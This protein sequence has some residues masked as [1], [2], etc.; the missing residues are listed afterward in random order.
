MVFSSVLFVCYFLPTL[1]VLYFIVPRQFKNL[2]LLLVS[3]FFYSWGAPKFIFAILLTTSI[4]FMLVS[5]MD[6]QE[7]QKRRKILMILSVLLNVSLLF[8]FKYCDFFIANINSLLATADIKPMKLLEVVLP[9]GI[10]FYTFESL[11][12]VIDVYRK[13]HQPLNDFINYLLYII[14]FPKLI[15]G[16]IIR[17]HEIAQQITH[18]FETHTID[19]VLI[20]FRRFA[21]GLSKKVIIANSLAIVVA[22][23]F[24]AQAKDLTAY[25]AWVGMIG[26]TF[27]I[28]FDFSGYSDMAIGIGQMLGF[29]F[30]ENFNNPYTSTSISD[31]WRKWHI[32]LGTWMKNYLY[33]PLGGNQVDSKFRLFFNLW[34]V[35]L[36]SGFW[37][38]AKWTFIF[39]GVYHG[40]WLVLD[41]LGFE[42]ILKKLGRLG[43]VFITFLLTAFGWVWFNANTFPEGTL[44][45]RKLFVFRES[46]LEINITPVFWVALLFSALFSFWNLLPRFP[47]LQEKL[48]FSKLNISSTMSLSILSLFFI[49]I[50]TSFMLTSQFNPFIYFRF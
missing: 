47:Q 1:L 32:T 41:R 7:T 33:I 35:F 38:G 39:W 25:Y 29:T 16:P 4:D 23:I 40:F 34:L 48:F 49:A 43:S 45:I 30:P 2:F 31:F 8:Y 5:W 10:S 46:D 28:Y 24:A 15:A 42:K 9:I 36:L 26:F 22:P 14:L 3:V 19:K 37:H 50:C 27:Q 44:F 17:Y 18:R 21:I 13:K 6:A 20:G 12:Y 11:T